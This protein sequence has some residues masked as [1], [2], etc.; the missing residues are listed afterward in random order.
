M[1]MDESDHAT[2]K[3]LNSLRRHAPIQRAR[4][5][6]YLQDITLYSS[7]YQLSDMGLV[8]KESRVK[9][10]ALQMAELIAQHIDLNRL[11]EWDIEVRFGDPLATLRNH[12]EEFNADLTVIGKSTQANVHGISAKQ[13]AREAASD[14]L[15]VP[16]QAKAKI[17]RIVVPFDF[18][19]LSIQAMDQALTLRDLHPDSLEI[20]ALHVFEVP[21]VN[22]YRIQ[23]TEA[24][25]TQM[26]QDDRRE[27]FDKIVKREWPT[28]WTHIEF[29]ALPKGNH[30]I[31]WQVM[32][33]AKRVS[34]SLII[35][36]AKG[37]SGLE[38]LL[39]GSV[40]E[41][42]VDLTEEIP[43]LIKR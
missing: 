16:D 12:I 40:A 35:L 31:G 37:H 30:T 34:A 25:M 43:V 32:D 2:I 3:F 4:F 19:T 42:V 5:V 14:V 24:Q 29:T 26:L 27:A 13:V 11:P 8:D 10:V 39:L 21:P 17:Q 41:R 9:G 20:H 38:R 7:L 18:S 22:W 6:H 33:W 36:G 28:H 1:D 23:R 15:I